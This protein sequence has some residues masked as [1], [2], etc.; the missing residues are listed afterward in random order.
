[1]HFEYYRIRDYKDKDKPYDYLEANVLN[2]KKIYVFLDEI[3]EVENF[4]HV[5][6][7]YTR[8]KMLIYI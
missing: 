3:Q 2:D 6:N 1:M 4:E 8:Q 7:H 5:V